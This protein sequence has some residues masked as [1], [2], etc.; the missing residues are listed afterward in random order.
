VSRQEL[1]ESRL[2]ALIQRARDG[3]QQAFAVLVDTYSERIYN[4]LA[5]MVGDR[6][7]ALDLAQDTFVR[8]WESLGRFHGGAAFSTW[9]YRIATNLAI[10]AA[11]RKGRRGRVESLDAPVETDDGEAERQLADPDRTPDEEVA[12]EE[13]RQ[14]VWR[15]VGE[16]PP[17][18]RSV[19]I[20]YDF[21]Q[22]SYEEISQALGVPLGTV[23]SRL[24]NARKTLRDKLAERL[25]MEEYLAS[26]EGRP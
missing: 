20:M 21:Q 5:R 17:K 13:L 19:L 4:Y 9:L 18:L 23:K 26:L 22:L 10:D 8:A 24:F 6:E 14:E 2:L 7:E 11:R 1:D 16:M 12:A 3:D 25:P 15:A